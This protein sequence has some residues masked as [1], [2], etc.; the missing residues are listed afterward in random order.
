MCSMIELLDGTL[1]KLTLPVPCR[2]CNAVVVQGM[3]IR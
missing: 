1:Q 2:L 3:I